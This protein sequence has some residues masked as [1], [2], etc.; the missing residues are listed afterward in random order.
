MVNL[1]SI[2]VRRDN[3]TYRRGVRAEGALQMLAKVARLP[4]EEL[5]RRRALFL[6]PST[7]EREVLIR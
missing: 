5:F 3:A 6:G 2:D 4:R 1:L 7:Q